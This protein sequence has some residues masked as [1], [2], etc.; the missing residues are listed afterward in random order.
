MLTVGE[1]LDRWR[2]RERTLSVKAIIRTKSWRQEIVQPVQKTMRKSGEPEYNARDK[3]KQD[4]RFVVKS[5]HWKDFEN[6]AETFVLDMASN[7]DSL[8]VP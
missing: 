3:V 5:L 6:N 2:E 1:D 8:Q 4:T 7:G